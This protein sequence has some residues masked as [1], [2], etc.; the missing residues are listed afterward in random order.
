MRIIPKLYKLKAKQLPCPCLANPS[1]FEI[2]KTDASNIG[3]GGILK[4]KNLNSHK[5][6]LVRFTYGM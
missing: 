1:W 4:Q 2:V 6:K 5:E 3:Y